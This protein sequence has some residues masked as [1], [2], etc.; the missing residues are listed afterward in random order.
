MD[1]TQPLRHES[2][3]L[4]YRLLGDP[5]RLRLLALASQEE[6]SIGEL[7]EVL[8]EAQPNISRQASQLRQSGLLV[9]RRSGTKAFLHTTPDIMHDP[10]ILDAVRVGRAI[11][12]KEGRFERLVAVLNRRHERTLEACC[13]TSRLR[14]R[15]PIAIEAPVFALA[16]RCISGLRRVAIDVGTGDGAMLD[17]LSPYFERVIAIDR[18]A[19]QLGLAAQRVRS[20]GYSNVELLCAE[21]ESIE[22]DAFLHRGDAVFAT[23]LLSQS[24]SPTSMMSKL[25]EL[26]APGGQLIVIDY[27]PNA[28]DS[29]SESI[30]D[31]STSITKHDLLTM[32]QQQGLLDPEWIDISPAFVGSTA[33][34]AKRWQLLSAR[35]PVDIDRT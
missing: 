27:Q 34:G 9:E 32:V 16:L 5:A 26:I 1:A 10:V 21:L 6:L 30:P 19:S 35:R 12:N 25:T 22:R 23:R 15:A 7:S 29:G 11:C 13:E 8:E 28:A 20:R 24:T 14:A 17:I 18:S 4:L 33:E 3:W 31:V 2:R